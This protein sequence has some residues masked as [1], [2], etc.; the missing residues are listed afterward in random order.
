MGAS[1]N[2]SSARLFWE[3]ERFGVRALR[4]LQRVAFDSRHE[5]HRVHGFDALREVAKLT[6]PRRTELE[7]GW[8]GNEREGRLA[9]TLE[10]GSD[11]A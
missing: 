5:L 2:H 3:I 7:A 8:G 11:D 4:E 6:T 10:S 9:G 1:R